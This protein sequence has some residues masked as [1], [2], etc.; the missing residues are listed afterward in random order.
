MVEPN[1][2]KFHIFLRF[3]L[4]TMTLLFK[5]NCVCVGGVIGGLEGCEVNIFW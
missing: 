2:Q 5:L 4:N 3:T 1:L